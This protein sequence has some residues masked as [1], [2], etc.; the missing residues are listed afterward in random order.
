MPRV[1]GDGAVSKKPT[2]QQ[3][4]RAGAMFTG[5]AASTL[6]GKAMQMALEKGYTGIQ[7]TFV[8][9]AEPDETE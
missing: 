1:R 3:L 7:I 5:M 2:S 8:K 9:E 6:I 4:E